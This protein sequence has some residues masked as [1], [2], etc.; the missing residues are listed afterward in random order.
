MHCRSEAK[1]D[2]KKD[3]LLD[4]PHSIRKRTDPR[5]AGLARFLPP[6]HKLR[7]LTRSRGNQRVP[8]I[9]K[10]EHHPENIVFVNEKVSF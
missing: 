6:Q 1:K 7:L 2:F 9:P 4:L 3:P 5:V 10:A 8:G